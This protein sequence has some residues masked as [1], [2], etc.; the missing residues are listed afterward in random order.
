MHFVHAEYLLSLGVVLPAI[1]LIA[2]A[3]FKA[4]L[5][6]RQ[7][8]GEQ[9]L[10]DRYTRRVTLAKHMA[11]ATLWAACAALLV[12]ATA[13]PTLPESPD[14]VKAGTMQVI[15][16]MDVSKSSGAEDYRGQMP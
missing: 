7:N 2:W 1:F 9:R 10:V 8:Y 6:A 13:G 16:V 14:Q 15:V 3:G 4:K 11:F 5:A 12:V